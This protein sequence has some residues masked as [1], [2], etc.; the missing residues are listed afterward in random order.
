VSIGS[1]LVAEPLV[2]LALGEKWLGA[3]P[4]IQFLSC[5]FGLSTLSSAVQPLA[6]ALGKTR[7]LFHRSVLILVIR[8]PAIVLGLFLGGL[9]GLLLA[10]TITGVIGILVNMFFVRQLIGLPIL[11]QILANARTLFNAALMA[12]VVLIVDGGLSHE[13][14]IGALITRLSCLAGT[15]AAVYAASSLA[16]WLLA[17]KPRGLESELIGAMM[18]LKRRLSSPRSA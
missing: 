3:V 6:L 10:R 4:V 7:T 9:Y 1:A 11:R 2:R 13:P 15:G 16:S 14:T 18:A 8:L 17:G 5:I 12:L